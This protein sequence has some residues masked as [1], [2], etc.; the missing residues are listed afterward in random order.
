MIDDIEIF[1][2]DSRSFGASAP[3]SPVSP[4]RRFAAPQSSGPAREADRLIWRGVQVVN[5]VS[6]APP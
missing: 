2:M 4:R 6:H 1:M 3:T 5:A